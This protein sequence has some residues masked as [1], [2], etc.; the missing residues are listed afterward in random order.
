MDALR[1]YE[2]AGGTGLTLVTLPYAEVQIHRGE[3]FAESYE[4]T[5]GLAR[6][7]REATSLKIN[8]A[9]GPYPVLIIP[10]AEAYGLEAAEDMLI[11]GMTFWCSATRWWP[12][13]RSEG[14]ISLFPRRYGTHP[15]ASCSAGWNWPRRSTAP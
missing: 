7:A 10:L 11:R 12:S 2:A 4:I 3:D 13:A 6:K 1:E 5:Y 14:P 15:T 8:I 9:V